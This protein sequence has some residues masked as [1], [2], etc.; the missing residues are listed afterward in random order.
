MR[1]EHS[2]HFCAKTFLLGLAIGF[3]VSCSQPLQSLGD[4]LVGTWQSENALRTYAFASSGSLTLTIPDSELWV[5]SDPRQ[6]TAN[7]AYSLGDYVAPTLHSQQAYICKAAGT[8]GSSE[9]IWEVAKPTT[10]GTATW[11]ASATYAEQGTW[12]LSGSTVTF[13]WSYRHPSP[14]SFAVYVISADRIRLTPPT[15]ALPIDLVRR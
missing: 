11:E 1:K 5:I 12:A 8:S 4:R 3:G 6:W 10:D 15:S 2:S 13:I 9:P 7:T 14:E